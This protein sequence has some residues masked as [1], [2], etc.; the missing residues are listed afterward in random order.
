MGLEVVG[1]S[2][3]WEEVKRAVLSSFV[4]EAGGRKSEG[5]PRR[6]EAS[7][8]S[9][10]REALSGVRSSRPSPGQGEDVR[11]LGPRAHG[12]ALVDDGATLHA[13]VYPR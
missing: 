11:V 12:A 9:L 2:D 10:V 6:P 5:A 13:T 3:T 7:V 8:R 1:R 4:S